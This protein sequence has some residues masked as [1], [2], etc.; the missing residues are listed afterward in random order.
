MSVREIVAHIRAAQ[1]L[2]TGLGIPNILQPGLVKELILAEA[3]GH[4]PI[5]SKASADARDAEGRLYEYLCSLSTSNNFQ[6]D[7]V[8]QENRERITRNEAFY[9]AFFSDSITLAEIC[10][11]ATPLVLQEAERQLARSRN[12]ISHLNLSGAW[13]RR[14]GVR[15][16]PPS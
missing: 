7:R 2:A 11:V 3:L 16:L 9:F 1:E 8:T 13:V 5:T 4:T 12:D 6:I 14:N 15:V 10:R